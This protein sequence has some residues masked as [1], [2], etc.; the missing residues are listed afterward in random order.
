MAER[1]WRDK[2]HIRVRRLFLISVIS[3]FISGMLDSSALA[4]SASWQ[5]AFLEQAQDAFRKAENVSFYL[6]NL[7][8]DIIPEMII[9]YGSS[10]EGEA[11]I[12]WDGTQ[13][14]SWE[15]EYYGC[16][17]IP[18]SSLICISGGG[19][20]SY[21]DEV[22]RLESGT[23]SMVGGG[24][25]ISNTENPEYGEDGQLLMND[26]FDY[27]WEGENVSSSEYM[28]LL[29]DAFEEDQAESPYLQ[30]Y[31]LIEM[32]DA[33]R[34]ETYLDTASF[35]D[36]VVQAESERMSDETSEVPAD[37]K[38]TGYMEFVSSDVSEYPNVKLYFDFTN[39]YGDPIIL[40]SMTGSVEE[41]IA[42]GTEI[43]RTIRKIERLEGKQGLSIDIVA[44]K[45]GS[46]EY[47]L[48][49]MQEIMSDFVAS[50]DY[51]SGDQVEI[52]S[53]DSYVMYMCTYT[54]DVDFLQNG[55]FNMTAYGETA[56]YDALV[57]GIT[58]AGSQAGARC[59]IG[60]TDGED[61]ASIYTEQEVI[62]LALQKEVPV[63]LIGT[64]GADSWILEEICEETGGYYW[65]IDSIYDVEEILQFIYS[66]QKDMYCIEYVS[67][68]EADPYSLRRVNC[69][70]E[71]NEYIGRINGLDFSA[72][73]VIQQKQH[74]SRYEFIHADVSWTEAND[75]C[76]A[77]GGHLATI[78][79][80]AEMDQ[81][82]SMCELEGV[83]Y[84][85]IGGYTS[86]RNGTA[87]GHW[88]TG[89]PFAFTSWYPGE[90][91]R[92]DEDGTPEFYLMLWKVED[93]WSWNDQRDDVLAS[94]LSYFE[95][96]IG[97]VCEYES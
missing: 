33:V 30:S 80:Q 59:V 26:Q 50:L 72:V 92:N 10:E 74:S 5:D 16:S 60:F 70:L 55:I 96:N 75:D 1:E 45:S 95:N 88:I 61:N 25:Y 39:E 40:S 53:F 15:Y 34:N 18:G 2:P 81:L 66:E 94:G 24:N 90:P 36:F 57:T 22:Y 58:N 19:Q 82:V 73:P 65:D 85:W 43:E 8:G 64:S 9:N 69:T 87:F 12:T 7:D 91:S 67:D 97:Y 93:E 31:D 29:H 41:R 13:T 6:I 4:A 56:L 23:F 52:L 68:S 49:E 47:D 76:I 51:A 20:G 46:M 35:S 71:D 63:Y 42:D 27:I 77:R 89:E 37:K 84:C 21:Y 38:R 3:F 78:T 86:I 17:Y 28:E 44:D 83:K 79:S 14:S 62:N 11:L 32:V 48:P 54:R